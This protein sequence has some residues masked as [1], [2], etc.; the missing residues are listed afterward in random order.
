MNARI[1]LIVM[2]LIAAPAWAQHGKPTGSPLPSLVDSA[3]IEL[4]Q[5]D[6]TL[7]WKALGEVTT[8]RRENTDKRYG[9]GI[10]YFMEPVLAP[11][12]KALAGKTVR[13]NGYVLPRKTSRDNE[14]YFLLSA[15]PALDEDGCEAGDHSTLVTVRLPGVHNMAVDRRVTVEGTLVLFDGQRW[16]GYIY[17]L[18]DAR[19][20]EQ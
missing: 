7:S 9:Q 13:V 4:V 18:T 5:K 15:L 16:D 19:I 11:R 20:L 6:G 17:R 2:S 12:V 10:A 3:S 14:T 1:P 8:V